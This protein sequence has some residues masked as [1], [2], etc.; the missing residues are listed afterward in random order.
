ML[1]T[2]V[3]IVYPYLPC[4]TALIGIIPTAVVI[5]SIKGMDA[6]TKPVPNED[7]YLRYIALIATLYI[8]ASVILTI[9]N[10]M[11]DVFIIMPVH[12]VLLTCLGAA[13]LEIATFVWWKLT[14]RKKIEDTPRSSWWRIVLGTM[15]TL[16]VTTVAY[17]VIN[18]I[19]M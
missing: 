10:N 18:V 12:Y 5:G 13:I 8:I 6:Q 11:T 3:N 4:L 7:I 2:I 15:P 19:T 1:N 17:I 16:I 14:D 9:I